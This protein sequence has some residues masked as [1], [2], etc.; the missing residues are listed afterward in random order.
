MVFDSLIMMITP[1][2]SSVVSGGVLPLSTIA[3]RTGRV[4][5]SS[6]DS[7]LLNLPGY[8]KVTATATFTAPEAG[9][10]EISLQKNGVSVPGITASTTVSTADT[11][12]SSIALSGIVRVF[13]VDS[14]ATLTLINSGVAIET[15]NI[16]IDVEYL[17]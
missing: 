3:R 8:Y 15:S 16:E 14:I 1:T 9:D 6:N 17:G 5:S 12:V 7:I 2:A 11:V 4:V 13:P 10:V